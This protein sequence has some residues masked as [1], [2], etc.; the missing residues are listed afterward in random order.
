M[1]LHHFSILVILFTN[2]FSICHGAQQKKR[3]SAGPRNRTPIMKPSLPPSSTE[4]K[5]PEPTNGNGQLV[6][7]Q[8]VS[9]ALSAGDNGRSYPT[10]P[11]ILGKDKI[12]VNLAIS[13]DSKET[14]LSNSSTNICI[15]NGCRVRGPDI[16]VVSQGFKYKTLG[17][18][19]VSGDF[20]KFE[21]FESV[22]GAGDQWKLPNFTLGFAWSNTRFDLLGPVDGVLGLGPGSTFLKALKEYTKVDDLGYALYLGK[23]K[24]SLT[25]GGFVPAQAKSRYKDFTT[26]ETGEY[27]LKVTSLFLEGKED[28]EFLRDADVII[29]PTFPDIAFPANMMDSLQSSTLK[30][31][32]G[33]NGTINFGPE[34]PEEGNRPVFLFDL[35]GVTINMT[36]KE[37]TLRG[38]PAFSRS[39]NGQVILGRPFL[40]SAYIV[41]ESSNTRFYV[42]QA[43][44]SQVFANPTQ[45]SSFNTDASGPESEQPHDG[46]DSIVTE[47]GEPQDTEEQGDEDTEDSP[48][49]SGRSNNTGIIVGVVVGGTSL[50]VIIIA[51]IFF[52]RRRSRRKIHE[53][54][55]YS[56]SPKQISEGSSYSLAATSDGAVVRSP[57]PPGTHEDCHLMAAY[58]AQPPGMGGRPISNFMEDLPGVGPVHPPTNMQY[59]YE[60]DDLPN[61]TRSPTATLRRDRDLVRTESVISDVVPSTGTQ[62]SRDVPR[63]PIHYDTRSEGPAL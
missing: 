33:E 30:L 35:E 9:L 61:M 7:S 56:G 11:V 16:P 21:T 48:S 12:K 4:T 26:S 25:I 37:Y 20:V 3:Q 53:I 24:G 54:K 45:L 19:E 36:E 63:L 44:T 46:D 27:R 39:Y 57:T 42:A 23:D 18:L 52:L 59:Q 8:I 13:L 32:V 47:P 49:V 58:A 28:E 31:V 51:I 38:R 6:G 60:Y 2:I 40:H 29:D 41:M 1:R 5:A 62:S 22:P 34:S 10:V 17:G 50:L 55:G 15:E 14:W 43:D